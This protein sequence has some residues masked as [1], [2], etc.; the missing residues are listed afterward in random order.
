MVEI[1]HEFKDDKT[2]LKLYKKSDYFFIYLRT[3]SADY[4]CINDCGSSTC[5]CKDKDWIQGSWNGIILEYDIDKIFSENIYDFLLNNID[6][7]SVL[8]RKEL[9]TWIRDSIYIFIESYY[10]K[11]LNDIKEC[12]DYLILNKVFTIKFFKEL[13]TAFELKYVDILNIDF[14]ES[15]QSNS[16]NNTSIDISTDSC[17]D[18]DSNTDIDSESDVESCPN[19]ETNEDLNN[20][21]EET[22]KNI[23]YYHV[24]LLNIEYNNILSKF[25]T[26]T[27]CNNDTYVS[28]KNIEKYMEILNIYNNVFEYNIIFEKYN[29]IH[30]S[31]NKDKFNDAINK[32]NIL[33]NDIQESWESILY[34]IPY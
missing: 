3:K 24:K 28:C 21:D 25:D 8:D 15:N 13:K 18:T 23:Q 19:S 16:T 1:I 29:I 5:Y 4:Y 9:S 27:S 20:L 34:H 7:L 26:N 32:F 14:S 11:E 22:S 33:F 12:I 30:K 6:K 17:A 31:E 2:L 10:Q